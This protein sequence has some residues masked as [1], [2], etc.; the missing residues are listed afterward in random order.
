MKIDID[1]DIIM[2]FIV[3]VSAI[4]ITI[5]HSFFISVY[6]H[7]LIIEE[8]VVHEQEAFQDAVSA[9]KRADDLEKELQSYRATAE[10]LESLGASH[11]QAVQVIK[12]S[13]VYNL[14]PKS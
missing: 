1:N 7:E 9:N 10:S 8:L 6:E 12:A 14:N 13:E 5:M 3:G 2:P 11:S 4:I